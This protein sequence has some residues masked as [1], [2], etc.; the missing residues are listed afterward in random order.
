MK[1]TRRGFLKK[2]GSAATAA[3]LSAHAAERRFA[4]QTKKPRDFKGLYAAL[5]KMKGMRIGKTVQNPG[6][7]KTVILYKDIH[8]GE[9]PYG[10][11][12]NYKLLEAMRK[13]LGIET[14]GIEG[15]AGHDVDKK[16]GFMLL[17]AEEDLIRQLVRNRKYK[18]I[19]LEEEKLQEAVLNEILWDHYIG[20]KET[21]KRVALIEQEPGISPVKEAALKQLRASLEIR[22]QEFLYYAKKRNVQPTERSLMEVRKKL[23][24]YFG[25]IYDSATEKFAWDKKFEEKTQLIERSR[26]GVSRLVK[27][28]NASGTDAAIMFFGA[29]HEQSILEEF[30]KHGGFNVVAVNSIEEFNAWMDHVRSIMKKMHK[31]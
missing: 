3:V 26:T 11:K 2:L 15:W 21:E 22:R 18:V 12:I 23:L 9:L 1:Y 14:V 8:G 27:E 29:G 30:K 19:G 16:R 31:E 13:N 5:S 17:N 20:F 25:E 4:A 28:M 10:W 24:D 7:T 6:A